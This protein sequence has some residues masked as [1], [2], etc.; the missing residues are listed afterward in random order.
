MI[1]DVVIPYSDWP[2]WLQVLI[3]APNALLAGY[4][5]WAWWPESKREWNKFGFVMAYLVVFFLVMR[6]VFHFR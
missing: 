6:F 5:C 4:A 1:S 2:G 3:G